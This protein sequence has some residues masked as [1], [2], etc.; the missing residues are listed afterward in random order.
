[1]GRSCRTS[2]PCSSKC[3]SSL[4]SVHVVLGLTTLQAP[5]TVGIFV[6]NAKT[7]AS[8]GFFKIHLFSTPYLIHIF[9]HIQSSPAVRP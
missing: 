5:L 2:I 6:I 1:M 3:N 8:K 7:N 4:C 9:R